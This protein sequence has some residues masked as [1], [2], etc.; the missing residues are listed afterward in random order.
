M[1]GRERFD[2]DNA[3]C[4]AEAVAFCVEHGAKCGVTVA[5]VPSLR[6]YISFAHTIDASIDLAKLSGA[7]IVA[8]VATGTPSAT[9]G[10]RI[11]LVQLSDVDIGTAIQPGRCERTLPDE[12]ELS[13]ADFVKASCKAGYTGPFEI[14]FLGSELIEAG[15]HAR[16]RAHTSRLLN[17][18]IGS[19]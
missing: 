3:P 4:Y 5:F 8:D 12:G 15:A 16:G 6:P 17:E 1:S 13:L 14:E 10:L 18:T 7:D 19:D 11:A 9:L 2:E